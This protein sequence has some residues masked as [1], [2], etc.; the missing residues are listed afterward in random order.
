[1]SSVEDWEGQTSDSLIS[2]GMQPWVMPSK[3]TDTTVATGVPQENSDDIGYVRVHPS[4]SV[5]NSFPPHRTSRGTISRAV[6][7]P[8]VTDFPTAITAPCVPLGL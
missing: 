4:P 5:W 1:M 3:L 8:V 7:S 6:S 2:L